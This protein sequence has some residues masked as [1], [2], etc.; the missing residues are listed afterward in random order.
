VTTIQNPETDR[1]F[2]KR[3][4][5]F[6][7]AMRDVFRLGQRLPSIWRVWVRGEIEPTLREDPV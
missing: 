5:V 7:I 4:Y 6:G 1:P 3:T 2:R